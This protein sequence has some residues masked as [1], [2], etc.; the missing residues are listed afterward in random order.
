MTQR[1]VLSGLAFAVVVAAVAGHYAGRAI[2]Y[3]L[4][5]PSW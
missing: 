2:V 5:H 3:R 4:A 1:T